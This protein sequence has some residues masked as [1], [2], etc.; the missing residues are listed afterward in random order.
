MH[1]YININEDVED[2]VN[3]ICKYQCPKPAMKY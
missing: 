3:P 2:N 1:K